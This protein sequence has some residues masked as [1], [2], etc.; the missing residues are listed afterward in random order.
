MIT[1][2]VLQVQREETL[3]GGVICQYFS[4]DQFV[5]NLNPN[6][7]LHYGHQL[8]AS[9]VVSL[10]VNRKEVDNVSLADYISTHYR[11]EMKS[12]KYKMH[13]MAHYIN[14]LGNSFCPTGSIDTLSQIIKKNYKIRLT[15]ELLED[16]GG[17]ID[18]VP[19]EALSSFLRTSL[20]EIDAD[21]SEDTEKSLEDITATA[22]HQIELENSGKVVGVP[23]GFKDLDKITGGLSPSE[24][25]VVAARPGM[26]KSALALTIAS[27]VAFRQSLPVL[28]YSLEM[29]EESLAK[30][31]LVSEA[32]SR[33]DTKK[34]NSVRIPGYYRLL[35]KP[36]ITLDA[37]RLSIKEEKAKLGDVPLVV[38]DHLGLIKTSAKSSYEATKLISH[39]LKSLAGEFSTC[40]LAL[41]QLSRK[42]EERQDKRPMLSDLRDSGSI[43]EDA[44]EVFLLYR[45]GYYS[46]TPDNTANVFVGKNRDGSTGGVGLIFNPA[47]TLFS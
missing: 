20:D 24:L 41:A 14:D 39:E 17:M 31:I 26:G 6:W 37:L 36:S 45:P 40:V 22:I 7:F 33:T 43:E 35:Y 29:P 4:A 13:D 27:N 47:L 28:Y 15:Q 11:S 18:N 23:T 9:S 2:E 12:Y 34:I 32:K 19:P 25:V 44:D 21:L 5:S 8:I 3:L 10:W 46:D 38:V 42:V 16:A 1:A 30:R